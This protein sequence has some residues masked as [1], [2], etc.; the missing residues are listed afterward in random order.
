MNATQQ[1]MLDTYRAAQ[2]GEAAPILPGTGS[3][4]AA[5]EIRPGR[6][7]RAIR[8]MR[9]ALAARGETHVQCR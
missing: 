9:A 2:R 5:R 3:V 8:R 7:V 1:H 4:R 6:V